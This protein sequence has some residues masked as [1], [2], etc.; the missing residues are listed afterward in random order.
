LP[1]GALH[2]AVMTA[3]AFVVEPFSGGCMFIIPAYFMVLA[4]AIP[5]LRLQRFG[6]GMAVFLPYAVLGF[7]PTWYFEWHLSGSLIGLWGVFVWCLIGPLV[8]LTADLTF[9]LLPHSLD[10]RWRAVALGAVTGAAIYA[11]TWAALAVL[12]RDPQSGAHFRFFTEG[13]VFSL[14]WLAIN[15][16][17]AGYTA[18]SLLRRI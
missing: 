7:F 5:I 13:I 4:V 8:G 11:T 15:G 18:H 16:G 9:R 14:P 2:F 6:A 10:G 1:F 12:Y 3:G 17:F